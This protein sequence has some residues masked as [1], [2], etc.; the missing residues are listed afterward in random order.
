MRQFLK[1]LEARTEK[2]IKKKK[3]RNENDGSISYATPIEQ[4][5]IA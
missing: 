1:N 2:I 5:T 4:N 3:K